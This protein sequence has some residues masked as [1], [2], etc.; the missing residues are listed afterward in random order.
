MQWLIFADHQLESPWFS[1]PSEY[2]PCLRFVGRTEED[3]IAQVPCLRTE[4][5]FPPSQYMDIVMYHTTFIDRK[6][7]ITSHSSHSKDW[8][9]FITFKMNY[10]YS[11]HSIEWYLFI[12]FNTNDIYS[13]HSN[14]WYLFITFNRMISIHHI[15][16]NDIYSSHSKEWYLFITFHRI[17]S[18]HH[19]LKNNIKLSNLV[20][21]YLFNRR[22]LIHHIY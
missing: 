9:L 21:W 14:E 1:S 8:Y 20:E 13:S 16:K 22:I 10:I 12:T 2:D 18:N 6:N 4:Q 3:E 5:S 7:R 19:I 17:I 15:Q 11:S